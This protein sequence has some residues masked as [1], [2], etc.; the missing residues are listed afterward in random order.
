MN[1]L[2]AMLQKQ[3]SVIHIII[4][5]FLFNGYFTA[6]LS[7]FDLSVRQLYS[8]KMINGFYFLIFDPKRHRKTSSKI[9]FLLRPADFQAPSLS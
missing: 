8:S 5:Y 7:T 6:P 2:N 4:L 3:H 1:A 9:D